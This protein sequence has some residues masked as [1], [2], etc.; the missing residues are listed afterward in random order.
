MRLVAAFNCWDGIG[1]PL[2]PFGSSPTEAGL[3]PLKWPGE[4]LYHCWLVSVN[5]RNYREIRLIG[6]I[7]APAITR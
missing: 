3:P 7:K 2:F 4:L 6:G 5:A 1:Y